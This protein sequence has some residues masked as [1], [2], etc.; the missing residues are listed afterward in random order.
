M[1]ALS[2]GVT[3]E[4]A[5]ETAPEDV[6]VETPE[7]EETGEESSETEGEGGGEEPQETAEERAERLEKGNS[8]Q[9]LKIERQ[10][11][12][13]RDLNERYEK[14]AQELRKLT[15]IIEEQKPDAEPSIDDYKTHDE[16]NEAVKEFIRKS[17]KAEAHGEY[18]QEQRRIQHEQVIAERTKI[19]TTQ[20]VEYMA[21]NP[22]YKAASN[23]VESYV[24]GMTDVS[25]DVFEAVS[26]QLYDGN[27]PAVIDY[28]G[29]NDGENLAELGDISRMSPPRAAVE[30]YKIQ[31]KLLASPTK[32]ETR[33][34]TT[35][36]KTEKGSTKSA[37]PLSKRSGKDVLDWVKS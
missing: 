11:A 6:T 19:R 36:V 9:K 4:P 10:A 37:K 16:Y 30:I 26:S 35:P 31:Q 20:E 23:E 34:K 22:M 12:A 18:L 25:Y 21:E 28:F 8:T 32:K 15:Q 13:N 14:Q 24:N 7:T 17:A 29:S 5:E 27:V 3:A 1:T 33:P 2:E